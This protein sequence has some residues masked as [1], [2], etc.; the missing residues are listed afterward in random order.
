LV[1]RNALL[2]LNLG[3]HLLD[4]VARLDV[5]RDGLAREMSSQKSACCCCFFVAR[6]KKLKVV[7]LL[8]VI[9]SFF[10]LFVARLFVMTR[11]AV[12]TNKTR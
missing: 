11:N 2:V 8:F 6:K 3:L 5:E 12:E 7:A 1:W 9:F 4:G 10:S